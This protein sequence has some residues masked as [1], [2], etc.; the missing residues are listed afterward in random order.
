MKPQQGSWIKGRK[1]SLGEQSVREATE[2]AKAGGRG[3]TQLGNWLMHLEAKGGQSGK[4]GWVGFS[5]GSTTEFG[6]DLGHGKTW[7]AGT[8]H[9]DSLL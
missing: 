7:P 6:K 1:S 4:T 8:N 5:R 9:S 3:A 2:E